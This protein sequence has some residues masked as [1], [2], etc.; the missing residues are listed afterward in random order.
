MG[1]CSIQ[2]FLITV[3]II[4]LSA[5]V[6]YWLYLRRRNQR[7]VEYLGYASLQDLDT[8]SNSSSSFV[9]EFGGVSNFK[10]SD[11]TREDIERVFGPGDGLE[12]MYTYSSFFG[13]LPPNPEPEAGA[14]QPEPEAG[15][16]AGPDAQAAQQAAA[17]AQPVDPK[18]AIKSAIDGIINVPD[19]IAAFSQFIPDEHGEGYA[20]VTDPNKQIV[21]GYTQLL[22][23]S[24]PNEGFYWWSQDDNT[25]WASAFLNTLSFLRIGTDF[26]TPIDKTTNLWDAKKFR[27][28]IKAPEGVQSIS[29]AYQ[30][31]LAILQQNYINNNIV[32]ID[33]ERLG[34]YADYYR[35]RRLLAQAIDGNDYGVGRQGV[36]VRFLPYFIKSALVAFAINLDGIHYVSIVVVDGHYVFECNGGKLDRTEADKCPG[37]IKH[38]A[39]DLYCWPTIESYIKYRTNDDHDKRIFIELVAISLGNDQAYALD[40]K[41][42]PHLGK[43][44]IFTSLY[45]RDRAIT[46]SFFKWITIFMA[47]NYEYFKK[48]GFENIDDWNNNVNNP[49]KREYIASADGL[50]KYEQ[51]I[52]HPRFGDPNYLFEHG[53]SEIV[54]LFPKWDHND[55]RQVQAI[56]TLKQNFTA[57]I[58]SLQNFLSDR[59]LVDGMKVHVQALTD[60]LSRFP[61]NVEIKD[62][63]E[64]YKQ[65]VILIPSIIDLIYLFTDPK[66]VDTVINKQ[67]AGE[68]AAENLIIDQLNLIKSEVTARFTSTRDKLTALNPII[69]GIVAGG[70]PP[71]NLTELTNAFIAEATTYFTDF[72]IWMTILVYLENATQAPAEIQNQ[73]TTHFNACQ[74]VISFICNSFK[75]IVRKIADNQSITQ[76]AGILQPQIVAGINELNLVINRLGVINPDRTK[77]NKHPNLPENYKT[78]VNIGGRPQNAEIIA[79]TE[80]ALG[81]VEQYLA[82]NAARIG[83]IG[84]PRPEQQRVHQLLE[85]LKNCSEAV[86]KSKA[87]CDRIVTALIQIMLDLD[88]HNLNEH[89]QQQRQAFLQAVQNYERDFGHGFGLL[90]ANLRRLGEWFNNNPAVDPN[91]PV[92]PNLVNYEERMTKNVKS[93]KS[94]VT[95]VNDFLKALSEQINVRREGNEFQ[96]MI[97]FLDA[98]LA[99]VNVGVNVAAN[100]YG[101]SAE[102][103]FGR[104]VNERLFGQLFN[105]YRDVALELLLYFNPRVMLST[106]QTEAEKV[107]FLFFI[108]DML[109]HFHTKFYP[110]DIPPREQYYYNL[111]VREFWNIYNDPQ[112]REYFNLP[113]DESFYP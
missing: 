112:Y 13:G 87:A 105:D 2:H 36:N 62:G 50:T 9:K 81:D 83:D 100:N 73:A 35:E 17:A 107:E 61:D 38:N 45:H 34:V 97:A 103:D 79:N 86:G 67:A 64:Y 71:Q 53:M 27:D 78:V 76:D 16:V 75:M 47:K 7:Y 65:L 110:I 49:D 108:E 111:I 69:Q 37:Q 70:Q 99:K 58:P 8:S 102:E 15:A 24:D 25:C 60:M 84:V 90:V 92:E 56:T 3:C 93:L 44:V 31:S 42:D 48:I 77:L 52:Q 91:R 89:N 74:G 96:Q 12:S 68:A 29:L 66:L 101:L 57:I 88:L 106:L 39:Y 20:K 14:P 104:I 82:A 46:R 59:E 21:N 80:K 113:R 32:I 26:A 33:S 30:K 51:I 28:A 10:V 55:N 19:P 94:D 109:R 43:S 4:V 63:N 54:K 5:L 98:V 41:L 11:I 18:V 72:K 85:L 22:N 23:A 40:T 95:L 6:F 1:N